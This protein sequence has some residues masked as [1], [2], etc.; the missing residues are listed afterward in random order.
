MNQRI[1]RVQ[2]EIREVL[3]EILV[4]GEIKDPRVRGSGIITFTHVRVSGDLSHARVFFMVHGADEE[5]LERVRG[6]LESASGYMR[7][8]IGKKLRL[9]IVP[10]LIFEVDRVFEKE[11]K[12]EA[13]LRELAEEAGAKK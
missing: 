8:E 10:T 1:E 4:R 5:L 2:G 7:R 6:G 13:I 11:E 12:V 9:R 3:A